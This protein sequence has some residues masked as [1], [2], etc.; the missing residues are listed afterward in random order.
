MA[1]W[2]VLSLQATSGGSSSHSAPDRPSSA[3]WNDK[4]ND[5]SAGSLGSCWVDRG[6]T[7]HA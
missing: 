5:T 7:L 1:C 2:P 3:G 4:R 6:R